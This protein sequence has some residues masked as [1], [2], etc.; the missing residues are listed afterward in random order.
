MVLIG[1]TAGATVTKEIVA[2]GLVMRGVVDIFWDNIDREIDLIGQGTSILQV[3]V[4]RSK[5]GCLETV[6]SMVQP[7]TRAS[8]L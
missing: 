5:I 4:M 2:E 6:L 7:I 3:F 1:L 8:L